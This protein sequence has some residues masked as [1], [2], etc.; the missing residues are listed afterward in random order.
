MKRT[1]TQAS[2]SSSSN[3]NP[4]TTTTT[5]PAIDHA[6]KKFRFGPPLEGFVDTAT[7]SNTK[8]WLVKVPSLILKKWQD[9]KSGA[10]LGSLKIE[11]QQQ[12]PTSRPNYSSS[13]SSVQPQQQQQQRKSVP[14]PPKITFHL[15]DETLGVFNPVK[16]PHLYVMKIDTAQ[17]TRYK[18]EVRRMAERT[19][20]QQQRQQKQEDGG[21]ADQASSAL[22][23]PPPFDDED[24]EAINESRAIIS[25]PCIHVHGVVDQMF[26]MVPR[27]DSRNLSLV[28]QFSDQMNKKEDR[29]R[30][31]PDYPVSSLPMLKQ[32][33]PVMIKKKE[34]VKDKKFKKP[35]EELMKEIWDLFAHQPYWGLTELSEKTSQPAGYLKDEILAEIC[36]Y[37]KREPNKGKYELKKEY[38]AGATKEAEEIKRQEEEEWE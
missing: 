9:K 6:S 15:Q 20:Q 33:M 1:Y 38:R 17:Q 4:S 30:E 32:T 31:I 27:L 11:H 13:S 24:E 25:T 8:L 3:G 5:A 37:N 2:S 28:K 7:A 36:D 29:M 12:Q 22:P 16:A 19:Q 14:I 35:K 26:N 10:L 21:D 34:V 23:P 18:D